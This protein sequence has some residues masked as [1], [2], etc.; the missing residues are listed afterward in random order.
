[1]TKRKPDPI[2]DTM[3]EIFNIKGGEVAAVRGQFNKAIQVL[4]A[5]GDATPDEMWRR[6]KRM[7]KAWEVTCGPSGFA[8]NWGQFENQ[9]R[10]EAAADEGQRLMDAE[11][12]KRDE[13]ARIASYLESEVIAAM[14]WAWKT[15][16]P[17][18]SPLNHEQDPASWVP[19]MRRMVLKRLESNA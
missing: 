18:N 2:W 19:A 17:L 12:I 14:E 6:W 9:T 10:E 11:S 4:R 1:M 15:D 7:K 8:K 16:S 5:S 13:V 3:C